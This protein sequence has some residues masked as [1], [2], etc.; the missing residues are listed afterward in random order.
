[1][2]TTKREGK[3]GQNNNKIKKYSVP[4]YGEISLGALSVELLLFSQSSSGVPGVLT[5][6]AARHSAPPSERTIYH[7]RFSQIR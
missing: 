2:R 3:K 6:A 1:M 5:A 7:I 4:V